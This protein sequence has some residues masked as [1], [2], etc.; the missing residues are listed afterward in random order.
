MYIILYWRCDT[1]CISGF[2]DDVILSHNG[3]YGG[4]SNYRYRCSETTW[5]FVHRFHRLTVLII[6]HPFTLS[7]QA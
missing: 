5:H 7:F 2:V 4:M 1:L 6:H 3:P